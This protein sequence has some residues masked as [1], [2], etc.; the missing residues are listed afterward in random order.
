MREGVARSAK[1]YPC[2]HLH[3]THLQDVTDAL[4]Q[5][6]HALV[7]GEAYRP[8][9]ATL[10]AQ[11]ACQLQGTCLRQWAMQARSSLSVRK[12]GPFQSAL[13]TQA[14]RQFQDTRLRQQAM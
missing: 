13:I 8:L 2:P 1:S 9:K 10:I 3:G 11:A 6:G 14:A 7:V 12:C 4:C 5:T